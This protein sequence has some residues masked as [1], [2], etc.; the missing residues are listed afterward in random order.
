MRMHTY[1]QAFKHVRVYTLYAFVLVCV[2]IGTH[3]L[4]LRP[5]CM[6]PCRVEAAAYAPVALI[7]VFQ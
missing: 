4:S 3:V 5:R 6:S 1:V 7:D 2:H